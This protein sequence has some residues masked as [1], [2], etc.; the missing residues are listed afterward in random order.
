MYVLCIDDTSQSASW[1]TDYMMDA[2]ECVVNGEDGSL[3]GS[4]MQVC[5][6]SVLLRTVPSL[7]VV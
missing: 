7:V 6:L 3:E 4:D 1:L 2:A 5:I